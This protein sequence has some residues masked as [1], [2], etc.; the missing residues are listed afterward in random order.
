MTQNALVVF[1]QN[2]NGNDLVAGAINVVFFSGVVEVDGDIAGATRQRYGGIKH[3]TGDVVIGT[4]GVIARNLSLV[5]TAGAV[6]VTVER[7]VKAEAVGSC[8]GGIGR[9]LA[10]NRFNDV[11]LVG[12]VG[13]N[14]TDLNGH[15]GRNGGIGCLLRSGSDVDTTQQ[16]QRV[17]GSVDIVVSLV[18]IDVLGLG[19]GDGVPTG[20]QTGQSNLIGKGAHDGVAGMRNVVDEIDPQLVAC[21]GRAVQIDLRIDVGSRLVVLDGICGILPQLLPCAGSDIL[22][23]VGI[24][25]IDGLF[26]CI[27]CRSIGNN[28]RLDRLHLDRLVI[29]STNGKGGGIGSHACI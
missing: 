17:D 16:T 18:L 12:L 15:A 26:R 13:V 28:R 10:C 7:S 4:T 14:G 24:V 1:I 20:G 5:S 25:E 29:A 6:A 2:H 8:E 23:F 11:I 27:Q 9:G 19:N 3:L 21:T 22:R